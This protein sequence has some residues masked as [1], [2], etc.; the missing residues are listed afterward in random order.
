MRNQC[1]IFLSYEK[2][3]QKE[4]IIFP[5]LLFLFKENVAIIHLEAVL[6]LCCTCGLYSLSF[7]QMKLSALLWLELPFETI[8]IHHE[9]MNL[10]CPLPDVNYSCRNSRKTIPDA[11]KYQSL[12]FIH[13]FPCHSWCY[14][15]LW[16]TAWAEGARTDWLWEWTL[17]LSLQ[18]VPPGQVWRTLIEGVGQVC[19][20]FVLLLFMIYLHCG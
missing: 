20:K 5:L 4:A 8:P 6:S 11:F 19:G 7:L 1:F 17:F 18:A 3:C 9:A 13:I 16:L 12:D 14:L 10:Q 2:I 15:A